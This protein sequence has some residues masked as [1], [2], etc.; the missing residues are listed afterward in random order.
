MRRRTFSETE[1]N[2]Q[3][4]GPSAIAPEQLRAATHGPSIPKKGGSKANPRRATHPNV[5]LPS[6]INPRSPRTT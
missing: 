4:M 1:C 5:T 2:D 6:R 3:V